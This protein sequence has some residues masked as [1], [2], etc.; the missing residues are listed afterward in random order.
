MTNFLLRS[1]CNLIY[2]LGGFHVVL[3]LERLFRRRGHIVVLVY[4][5][6][7][8]NEDRTLGLS[9]LAEG[10]PI[11]VFERHICMFRRW[12]QPITLDELEQ[13]VAGRTKLRSDA[14]LV[15]FDDGY[16]DNRIIGGPCL[17]RYGLGGVI[18]V[19]TSFVDSP[20]RYWWV[21]LDDLL[22]SISPAD[23]RTAVFSLP[24]PVAIRHAMLLTEI[25]GLESRRY[26]R[27]R[28]SRLLHELAVEEQEQV[29]EHLAMFVGSRDPSCLPVLSWDEIRSM[30]GHGFDFG[31]HTHTHPRLPRLPG[32]AIRQGLR[33]SQAILAQQLGQPARSFAYPFG[34]YS[35][36]AVQA[37]AETGFRLAFTTKPG[38]I[39]PG[40]CR[41]HELPRIGLWR[42]GPGEITA[43]IVALKLT[44][45]LPRLTG[46]VLSRLLGEDLQ[47]RNPS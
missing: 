20:R 42:E 16:R 9:P 17:R 32:E 39:A 38:V 45:Y 37:V 29:L 31:G 6:L 1:F 44:K 30:H 34:E 12:Y 26:V 43:T 3:L 35:E 19:A 14:M 21:W 4:H 18:F 27:A 7:R 8:S 5:H 15:T 41:P 40:A 11:S 22:G 13:V 2:F 33:E 10:T 28:L 47:D 25:N 46:P 24:G 36:S 23:W